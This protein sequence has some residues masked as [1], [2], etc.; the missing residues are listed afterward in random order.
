[1]VL[2]KILAVFSFLAVT[3]GFTLVDDVPIQKFLFA[4]S[5]TMTQNLKN[6]LCSG[7]ILNKHWILTSADCVKKIGTPEHLSVRYGSHNRTHVDSVTKVV[8]KIVV[9]PEYVRKL[10]LNNL[11]LLRIE[12]EIKFIPT[13]VQPAVLPTVDTYEDEEV[14]VCGWEKVRVS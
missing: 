2:L 6:H 10:L 3:S 14:L 4:S 1:M 8:S 5:I 12:D 13:V 9:H 7:V 11:A